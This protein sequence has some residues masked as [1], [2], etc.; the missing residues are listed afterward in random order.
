QPWQG[1]EL[2]VPD[3]NLGRLVETPDEISAAAQAFVDSD[4]QLTLD[5][6]LVTG[7]DFFTD[8]ASQTAGA[9]SALAPDTL[10]N[11]TWSSDD[12]R[13]S[14][15]GTNCATH[16]L[17]AVNAH[18]THYAALSANGFTTTNFADF[19]T[20][21]E[22]ASA[23]GGS[24]LGGTLTFTIGCH[25]GLSVP[26]RQGIPPEA[27]LTVDPRLDFAQAMARQRA[28]YVANTGFGLG[29]SVGVAG[30][31][32]LMIIFAQELAKGGPA[33]DALATAKREYLLRQSTLSVYVEKSSITTTMYG[34][35][36]YVAAVPQVNPFSAPA[37]FSLNAVPATTNITVQDAAATIVAAPSLAEV[38]TA[39]GTYVAANGDAQSTVGR[40]IQPRVLLDLPEDAVNGPVHGIVV[41]GGTYQDT[42]PFDP[43]IAR[44]Q[45]EWD[46]NAQE[47]QVCLDAYWPSVFTLVNSLQTR[48]GLL[49]KAVITP[50][51]FR[52]T[53][54][55]A[56]TV[57]GLE[58]V[59]DSLQLDALRSTSSDFEPP[60]LAT[61]GLRI[62][63]DGTGN[64]RTIVD[65][66]DD[67]GIAE[68]VAYVLQNGQLI[69]ATTGPLSGAGPY[70]L[71]IPVAATED[72]R[73]VVQIVDGAGN[74]TTLTGKGANLRFVRVDAGPDQTVDIS[75]AATI[76]GTVFNFSD[77]IA[78]PVDVSY[79]WDFGDGTWDGGLLALDGIAQPSV[80]VDGSGNATFSVNHQYDP[81]T[82][83]IIIAT[84]TVFD[85]DGGV[86]IDSANNTIG[87]DGDEI[88]DEIDN[89][90][91]VFNP[92]QL[93][94]DGEPIL[95][96]KPV[97][98]YNDATNPN[99]DTLGD[100]C[101]GDADG[102]GLT[103]QDEN[104]RLLSP[105]VWDTDGDRTNDGTEV[106]CGSNPLQAVSNL[107]GTDTDRDNLPDSCE[108]V[109]GTDPNDVDSDEDGAQDGAEVRYWM[110]N[111]LSGDS[112]GDGC[113]DGREMGSVNADRRVNSIDLSQMAQLFGQ[114]PPEFR[115]FD[116]N[117]DGAINS[118]D[119]AFSARV[120]GP[121]EA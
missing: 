119:L 88:A 18:F 61:G 35:P 106:L 20:S 116:M 78:D 56:A 38:S 86:G 115:P 107:T 4:G 1:R 34:L 51:Q 75:G 55:S 70:T 33:G 114:L 101:D 17:N 117:G 91:S 28:V 71:D 62:V 63:D 93:N 49:Q 14:F 104:A 67:S 27:G 84:L 54:G 9:L 95:L 85:G 83:G 65:A 108:A 97:P 59:Y 23:G 100:A 66:T 74:V 94:T 103:A 26:D 46:V 53:S 8:G 81:N 37:E 11:D 3:W 79:V 15:L 109:Y 47:P 69:V 48:S 98:V 45:Q 105:L 2:Y 73:L 112:D 89:C 111:P 43:V 13:C 36:M 29:D 24:G 113:S 64:L 12:L 110:S 5:T 80:T 77:I 52:C 82:A 30:N 90:P 72:A 44:P 87:D 31:E 102:D 42:E 16:D 96:P 6:A 25:G 21:E 57:T 40:A 60:E 19:I 120:F 41:R 50:A 76:S 68:I 99:G 32:E 121:C 22:V 10:I 7:Y 118:L 39:D 58:R 92:D